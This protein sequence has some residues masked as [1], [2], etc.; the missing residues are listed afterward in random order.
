MEYIVVGIPLLELLLPVLVGLID[1]GVGEDMVD[2]GVV[3]ELVE[4]FAELDVSDEV[5]ELDVSEDTVEAT[6]LLV[7]GI[8]LVE[9]EEELEVC[10]ELSVPLSVEL[11]VW[12]D[13]V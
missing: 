2:E 9:V 7:V 6:V 4:L 10:D 3:T 8:E 1:V 11:F 5:E 12:D 13:V